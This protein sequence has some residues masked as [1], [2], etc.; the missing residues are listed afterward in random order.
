MSALSDLQAI[1]TIDPD[2]VAVDI[3]TGTS[4]RRCRGF[5]SVQRMLTGQADGFGVPTVV[6]TLRVLAGALGTPSADAVVTIGRVAYHLIS[7]EPADG[8]GLEEIARL[9]KVTV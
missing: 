2:A 5:L 1:Y 3:G 9:A 6:T 4:R 7:L 8:D